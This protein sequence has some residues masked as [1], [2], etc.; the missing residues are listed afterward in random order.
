VHTSTQPLL[1]VIRPTLIA[2]DAYLKRLEDSIL[3]SVKNENSREDY[4]KQ[5][6]F[7]IVF[8]HP[9]S[10]KWNPPKKAYTIRCF[11]DSG[12]GIYQALNIGINHAIGKSI[13]I[14]NSDDWIDLTVLT[15]IAEKYKSYPRFALYGN[16]YLHENNNKKIYIKGLNSNNTIRWARMPG[17]HQSQL[18]TKNI[19]EQM[20]FFHSKIGIGPFKIPIKYASD[21]EFYSRTVKAGIVW[22]YEEDILANQM[23]GGATSVHWARTVLEIYFITLKY[24]DFSISLLIFLLRSFIG[25]FHFHFF[26]K[27]KTYKHLNRKI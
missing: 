12:E 5:N 14:I 20:G 2:P 9:T 19:Y 27:L 3:E 17:S 15:A 6:L 24:S 13:T 16:T 21:F 11:E 4:Y 23:M 1:S 26:S 18:I 7:E 22:K 10:L 25:A 8:I